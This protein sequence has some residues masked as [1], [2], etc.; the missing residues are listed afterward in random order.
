MSTH[1]YST[2]RQKLT[3]GGDRRRH[4]RRVLRKDDRE[5]SLKMEINMAMEEPRPRVVRREPDRHII[6]RRTRAHHI[7][8]RR[9][10]VVVLRLPRP[11]H[12]VERVP[13]QVERVR[14]PRRVR[15]R[16]GERDL[17][18]RVRGE[19][20]HAA[21]REQVRRGGRAREDLEEDGDGG[22]DEGRAVDEELGAVERE[23]EVQR[24]VDAADRGRAGCREVRE[25]HER[26]L[27]ERVAAPR[28]S[29]GRLDRVRAVVAEDGGVHA[30][31]EGL[32]ADVGERADPVVVDGLVG[33]EDE[34]VAL[35]GEDL[36]LVDGER[37]V[38][39]GVDLDDVHGVVVDR[40]REVGVARERDKAEAVALALR[41]GEHG[42]IR[43]VTAGESTKAVDQDGIGTATVQNDQYGGRDATT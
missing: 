38:V 14:G 32:G 6:P 41:D 36:Y 28:L 35:P 4:V 11:A 29:G 22:R 17:D 21:P 10:H 13:V 34:R 18:R 37:G 2:K 8:L 31:G 16:H 43:R 27:D 42:E 1:R 26:R 15:R 19:G 25:R 7:A 9:V 20:V 30:A 39:H 12:D 23:R 33:G 5:P 24:E 40:E 3:R